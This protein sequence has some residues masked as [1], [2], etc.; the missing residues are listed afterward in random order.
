MK[1][2]MP[3]SLSRS[4][5]MLLTATAAALPLAG[6][7]QSFCAS[8]GQPRP[9]QL[10]ERF[11]NAD[12]DTCWSDA[13]TPRATPGQVALD[14]VL[15]G[16]KGDDAPLSAVATRDA[17]ARLESLRQPVPA[18]A[19]AY[20]QPAG[21]LRGAT[22][23]VSHGVPMTDYVGASIELKPI[24]AAA[25]KHVWTGWLALVETLPAGTEGSPVERNLVRNLLQTTWDGGKPLSKSEQNRFFDARSMGVSSGITT[26]RLRVVGWVE[27][28]KGRVLA[29][30][31]SRCETPK[32]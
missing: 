7:A 15:P 22:L 25:K 3:F 27:D 23:R 11:I 28:A 16:S 12:C 2:L 31:Q 1:V 9:A 32:P 20:T 17:Q 18:G 24:P 6:H 5:A 21:N 29:A 26:S 14:W 13:A 4:A 10:L 19:A 8:D 30:A